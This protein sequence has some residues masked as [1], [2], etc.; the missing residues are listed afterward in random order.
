MGGGVIFPFT[1]LVLFC[2]R[3]LP[4]TS[5]GYDLGSQDT[6]RFVCQTCML[7]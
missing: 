4:I 6:D 3:R 2:D 7:S 1:P 5:G